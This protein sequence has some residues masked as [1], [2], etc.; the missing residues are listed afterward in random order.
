MYLSLTSTIKIF[1]TVSEEDESKGYKQ[2]SEPYWPHSLHCKELFLSV[3][4]ISAYNK[5]GSLMLVQI[6]PAKTLFFFFDAW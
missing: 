4:W 1:I 2:A 6:T 5:N 3:D